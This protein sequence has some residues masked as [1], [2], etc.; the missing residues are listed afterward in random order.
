MSDDTMDFNEAIIAEFRANGGRTEAFGEAPLLILTT[1]GAKS[2]E[3]RPSPLMYQA[4]DG[5]ADTIYVFASYAG[6][7]VNP[8]WYHNVL[9]NPEVT[10]EL[11]TETRRGTAR[12]LDEPRRS[13]VYATQAERFPAFAEYEQKTDRVIPVV[14]VD[15]AG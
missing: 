1:T 14:A 15:L 4:D 7:D 10:V 8:A 9:A 3:Q 12:V 5:D 6:A 13:E 2:G 11:G